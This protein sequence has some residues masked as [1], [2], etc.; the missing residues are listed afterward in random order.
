MAIDKIQSES[1]N[2]ADN[3]AFTGTVT[4]A[5]GITQA[6]VWRIIDGAG[7]ATSNTRTVI[8]GTWE[9]ADDPANGY[10]GSGMS[11]SSGI[12]TFPSTGFYLV[13]FIA[14]YYASAD[15]RYVSAIIE[16]TTDNANYDRV[17]VGRSHIEYSYGTTYAQPTTSTIIDV[18]N[19]SNVKVRFLSQSENSATLNTATDENYTYAVFIRLGD[20]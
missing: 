17:A 1:I 10:I 5:G 7:V 14:Q 9:R 4:G 11:Q 8:T 19:T 13:E 6:D 3:F 12:F 2:L 16:A 18:T 20:T 15:R